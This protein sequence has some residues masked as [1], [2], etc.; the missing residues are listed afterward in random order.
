MREMPGVE[1]PA[2]PCDHATMHVAFELSKATWK[3][4]VVLPGSQKTRRYTLAR[5]DTSGS[6]IASGSPP[7]RSARNAA[8]R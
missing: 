3:I 5:G 8:S 6:H 2:A 1:P 4:G 7:R